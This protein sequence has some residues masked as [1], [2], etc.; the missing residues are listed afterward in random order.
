MNG[1]LK[2]LVVVGVLA[3]IIAGAL[4]AFWPQLFEL[5]ESEMIRAKRIEH[6][7]LAST[8]QTL[9][10][11]PD[12]TDLPGRLSA[13][14]MTLG[15]PVLL[16]I[17]KREFELE[18]WLK[19]GDRYERFATYPIC[20]WSG[21][22]GPKLKQGDRQSPEGFYTVD[23]TAL[24]PNSS[25]HLS[26]NLGFPNAFDRSHGRTGSFLMV[27]GDCRSIGCYAMTDAVID[28]VWKLVTSALDNGQARFQAQVYPFRMTDKNMA[29]HAKDKNASYWRQLKEGN[30]LF[31]RSNIPPQVN[32][33]RG[34]YVF[35]P[36]S[37]SETE[38]ISEKCPA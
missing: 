29:W 37:P 12:L 22:L 30:D 6:W 27:H 18:V 17:F 10:D 3:A 14:G 19:K 28:E 32:V 9:P 8:G 11:T 15:A 20:M 38:V 1:L 24:N 4:V 21:N 26:F 23:K 13:K 2:T 33:C 31:E 7:T 36:G 16:R 34:R 35:Q 25:Y 5:Y